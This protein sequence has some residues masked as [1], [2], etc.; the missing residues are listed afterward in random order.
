MSTTSD[1]ELLGAGREAE[2]FAWEDG[3]VLRLAREPSADAM[4]EREVTAL[5]AAQRAG[6]HVPRVYERVTVDGRPGVVLERV[7]GIDLLGSLAGRPWTVRAV[8]RT[9][10]VEH[11]GLHRVE[12]PPG[13]PDLH[14]ELRHRLASPLVPDEVRA[15]ALERLEALPSG[16]QLLHGDF[17]P[18]NLLR[19]T[20]GYVVIDWTNGASGDP[21]A[22]VARTI[23]LMSGG[24]PADGTALVVRVIAPVAR[25]VLIAGYLSAYTR[26]MPLDRDLVDRWLP[27]WAAARLAE[28]IEAE[29]RFLLDRAR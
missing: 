11:A 15:H 6:A 22:D 18:A 13:L 24:K 23:L 1:L 14:D 5:A 20:N 27:V 19:S 12:A 28:D 26:E 2:I 7:D 29:R 8:G 10:G 25:R 4:I 16:D 9:L 3:R 21:A 17:H